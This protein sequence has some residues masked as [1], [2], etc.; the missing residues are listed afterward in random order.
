M[1]RMTDKVVLS[2]AAIHKELAVAKTVGQKATVNAITKFCEIFAIPLDTAKVTAQV[3]EF[4]A[5][6]V[7]LNSKA[8]AEVGEAEAEG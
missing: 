3:D 6:L 2:S 4:K 8:P 5:I 1:P 7:M